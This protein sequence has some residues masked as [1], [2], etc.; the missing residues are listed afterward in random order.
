MSEDCRCLKDC[1]PDGVRHYS[2]FE[3]T[4]LGVDETSGRFAEVSLERCKACGRLWIRYYV[5]YEAFSQSGRWAA[6]LISEQD[7]ATIKPEQVAD[8][9]A[10]LEW[11]II[12]GSYYRRPGKRTNYP[13][14][15]SWG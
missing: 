2:W 14:D 13:G 11:C 4:A 9:L 7:A 3:S 12:G 5:E 8:Y 1:P 6:G 15:I 10:K